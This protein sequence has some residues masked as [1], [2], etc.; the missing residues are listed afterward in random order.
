MKKISKTQIDQLG[1]RLRK[2]PLSE[3]DLGILDDYRKSFG[4]AY[5]EV[6]RAIRGKLNLEPTGRPAKSTSSIIEKLHRESIRLSQMQDIAGC[7]VVVADIQKQNNVVERLRKVFPSASVVDRRIHPSYGYRAIHV[8]IKKLEKAIEVQIRTEL[9]HGWSEF[10]EKLSDKIDPSIKY[11]GGDKE[12]Q[13]LLCDISTFIK[14]YEKAEIDILSISKDSSY[15]ELRKKMANIKKG[16]ADLIN[17]HSKLF[18]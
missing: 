13:K 16:I 14:N 12:I 5:E 7:R 3:A 18:L 10:S 9:Q 1:D 15:E 2:A 17:K 11:G 4:V 8:I 6:V